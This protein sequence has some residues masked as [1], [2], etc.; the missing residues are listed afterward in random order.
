[1]H[2]LTSATALLAAIL[3]TGCATDP[4]GAFPREFTNAPDHFEFETLDDV[5]G[6]TRTETFQWSNT[7]TSAAVVSS[8]STSA[9]E[10]RLILRDAA[11]TEVFDGTLTAALDDVSDLGVAGEWTIDLALTGYSGSIRFTVENPT[12]TTG[13]GS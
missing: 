2:K 7:G 12:A 6:I 13:I 8:T 9:G 3:V 11:G 10:A 5:S 4:L 1:M